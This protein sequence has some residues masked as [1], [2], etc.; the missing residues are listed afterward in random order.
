MFA[1][2]SLQDF[3]VKVSFDRTA[4]LIFLLMVQA[5][6]GDFCTVLKDLSLVG[7]CSIFE[8]FRRVATEGTVDQRLTMLIENF[9]TR[10]VQSKGIENMDNPSIPPGLDFVE[11]EEQITHN[12]DLEQPA[13]AKP[14]LD[15]FRFDP[16]FQEHEAEFKV[17]GVVILNYYAR[18]P[19]P[20]PLPLSMCFL[21][22]AISYRP[23]MCR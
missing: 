23:E 4:W 13:Q 15:V 20:S 12:V 9:F 1:S 6:Q 11:V 3:D 5:Q 19:P 8:R 17:S 22:V 21:V 2:K 7:G 14:G 18:F 10:M 16:D